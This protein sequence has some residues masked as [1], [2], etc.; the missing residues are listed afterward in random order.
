M[1]PH[2]GR[3]I[4]PKLQHKRGALLSCQRRLDH[5]QPAAGGDFW[6]LP[7]V[8]IEDSNPR[9]KTP[10]TIE[11]AVSPPCLLLNPG[12]QRYYR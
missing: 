12:R 4:C 11:D 9:A 2:G 5:E 3:R 10:G 6:A 7:S 8:P 1:L